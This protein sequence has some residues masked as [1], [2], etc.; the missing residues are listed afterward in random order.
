MSPTVTPT[1]KARR[2]IAMTTT[3]H[4]AETGTT[5]LIPL[6][7]LKKSPKNVRK[8]LHPQTDIEALA[9]TIAAKGL[10]QNL[11]VEPEL[12]GEGKPTGYYPVTIGEGVSPRP[13]P[14]SPP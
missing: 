14:T 13:R 5:L 6:N 12:D 11:V 8:T 4:T 7:R 9:A 10:L 2:R 1:T 3:T